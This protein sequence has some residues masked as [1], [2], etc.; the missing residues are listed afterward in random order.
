MTKPVRLQLSR[1]AGFNLQAF[2]HE[3]NGL[4]A[5]N[6]ARPGFWGNPFVVNSKV[7]TQKVVIGATYHA[8][9]TAAEAIARFREFLP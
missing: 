1:A 3:T 5:V 6:V 7:A 9:P 2:S 8:V 4:P